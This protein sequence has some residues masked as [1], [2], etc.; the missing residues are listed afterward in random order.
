MAYVKKVFATGRS[1][2]NVLLNKEWNIKPYSYKLSDNS[3]NNLSKKIC[4]LIKDGNLSVNDTALVWKT[5][6]FAPS[7]TNAKFF[8]LSG[9]YVMRIAGYDDAIVSVGK[10]YALSGNQIVLAGNASLSNEI[11]LVN[12]TS[13][14]LIV[15]IIK[16]TTPVQ[17][18]SV[19]TTTYKGWY[20]RPTFWIYGTSNI[21]ETVDVNSF[22]TEMS[23]IGITSAEISTT[24]SSGYSFTLTNVTYS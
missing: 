13:G 22:N 11:Q 14:T 16:Q 17:V 1:A 10:A 19:P 4:L 24:Y 3:N 2:N 5:F 15:T 18:T 20:F 21:N 6:Y 7:A 23:V 8:N 12:N 9:N